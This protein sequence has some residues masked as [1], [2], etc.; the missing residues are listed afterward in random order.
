[1]RGTLEISDL[2]MQMTVKTEAFR[3]VLILYPFLMTAGLKLETIHHPT[4]FSGS[5]P[6]LL[7]SD[8]FDL[9]LHWGL[10]YTPVKKI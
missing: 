6:W 1:M 2:M 10:S 4:T 8:H 9:S 3:N 7:S 5:D